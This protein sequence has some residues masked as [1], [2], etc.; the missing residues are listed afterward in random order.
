M[1]RG[2]GLVPGPA[3]GEPRDHGREARTECRRDRSGTSPARDRSVGGELLGEALDSQLLEATPHGFHSIILARAP[4]SQGADGRPAQASGRRIEG[5]RS[6]IER[7]DDPATLAM[8]E[9]QA[10]APPVGSNQVDGAWPFPARVR[11]ALLTDG[12]DRLD[13]QSIATDPDL[14][15]P[16]ARGTP[17]AHLGGNDL[18]E[19]HVLASSHLFGPTVGW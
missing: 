4:D 7:L 17:N 13:T 19:G 12:I 10:H 6:G 9:G 16:A 1:K 18:D 15:G 5:E 2:V 11:C 8:T 3:Y 14:A